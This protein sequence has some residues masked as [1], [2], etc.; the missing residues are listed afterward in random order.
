MKLLFFIYS[1]ASG[2][3]E[4]V[5]ANLAN[6]WAGK[7]WNVT[8]VTIVSQEWDFYRLRPDVLRI[9]LELRS[10]STSV[11]MG[12]RNNMARIR[13][14]RA[15][16]KRE[17]PDMTVGMMSTANCLLALA[18]LGTGILTVGSE[19]VHPPKMPLGRSWDWLRRKTYSRLGAV[20]AQTALSAEWLKVHAGVRLSRVIPNPVVYP[21]A[22]QEPLVSPPSRK[23]DKDLQGLLLAAG[24]LDRQKGFDRLLAAFAMLASQFPGWRLA[25][26]GEG[27]DRADLEQQAADL[28]VSRCVVMPGTVGN[29][30][31]WYEAADVYVMTSR[32]EGFPNTLVEALA[33]G[34]PAVSVD[35]VTGPRDILRH[36]I[37]GLLVPEDNEKALVS[38]L[39]ELME[40]RHLRRR[41]ASR[42]VEVRE[43]YSLTVVALM[44]EDLFIELQARK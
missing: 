11:L 35:C 40:N 3:A 12:I 1:L 21:L 13:A 2:G 44:W 8:I 28:H 4:R 43:R 15:I 34:L 9:A 18:A 16:L 19:R 20:V 25:I 29:I 38:A 36:G 22:R 33:Y 23:S 7:G 26:V 6:Y 42:A 5:T 27:S 24:R 39:R 17:R 37:D 32:F 41:F 30:G 14:L 31:D 10:D